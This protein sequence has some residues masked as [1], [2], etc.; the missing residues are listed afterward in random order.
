MYQFIQYKKG[1]KNKSGR[2][3]WGQGG[4]KN[5][6]DIVGLYKATSPRRDGGVIVLGTD[7]WGHESRDK[8]WRQKGR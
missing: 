5:A 2:L 6:A 1:K 7:D 3:E 8:G 4:K